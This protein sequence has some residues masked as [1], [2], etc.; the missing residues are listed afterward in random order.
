MLASCLHTCC[1]NTVCIKLKGFKEL[2][3]LQTKSS[4]QL[5]NIKK[6]LKC[7][8]FSMYLSGWTSIKIH[9]TSQTNQSLSIG[10]H[11][12]GGY[13]RGLSV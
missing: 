6:Y 3:Q 4:N 12:S 8:F 13:M 11:T 2:N 7:F 5:S 10:A 1:A 9:C